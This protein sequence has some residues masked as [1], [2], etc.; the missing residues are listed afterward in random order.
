MTGYYDVHSFIIAHLVTFLTF[1]FVSR[2]FTCNE[3]KFSDVN[4]ELLLFMPVVFQCGLD[5]PPPFPPPPPFTV[6]G[7]YVMYFWVLWGEG[8]GGRGRREREGEEEG[9]GGGG[10]QM[11]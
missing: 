2:K 5:P 6:V 1:L 8:Q 10:T 4:K 9:G 3:E 7:L 11:I